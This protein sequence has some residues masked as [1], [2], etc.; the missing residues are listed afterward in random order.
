MIYSR[1]KLV[2][3][4]QEWEILSNFALVKPKDLRQPLG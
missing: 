1:K 2:L 3:L 4:L